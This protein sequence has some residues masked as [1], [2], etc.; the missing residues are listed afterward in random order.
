VAGTR[1]QSRSAIANERSMGSDA[2][3]RRPF[4]SLQAMRLPITLLCF[5]GTSPIG[6]AA[7][8]DRLACW[9]VSAWRRLWRKRIRFVSS[10]PTSISPSPIYDD[11][12]L[13]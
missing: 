5:S 2:L 3:T 12:V 13:D 11:M 8:P 6:S 7:E 10:P 4:T 9:M 1:W